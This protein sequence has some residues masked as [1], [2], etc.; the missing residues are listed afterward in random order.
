M[1]AY[2]NEGE[3]A[4]VPY[5]SLFSIAYKVK[6]DCFLVWHGYTDINNGTSVKGWV[7]ISSDGTNYRDIFRLHLSPYDTHPYSK[8]FDDVLDWF[9]MYIKKDMFVRCRYT[10]PKTVN[11][12]HDWVYIYELYE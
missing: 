3:H 9:S 2:E 8:N 10:E 7:Q 12:G 4:Y 11:K 6:H 1:E 5:G